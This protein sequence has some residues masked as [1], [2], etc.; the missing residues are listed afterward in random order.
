MGTV[1][2]IQDPNPKHSRYLHDFFIFLYQWIDNIHWMGTTWIRRFGRA[3]KWMKHWH[4]YQMQLQKVKLALGNILIDEMIT[5]RSDIDVWKSSIR[6]TFACPVLSTG[7]VT[8]PYVPIVHEYQ[9]SKDAT[10]P[11]KISILAKQYGKEV[12]S[13]SI[14][15]ASG[16]QY[17]QHQRKKWGNFSNSRSIW[18][19]KVNFSG[20]GLHFPLKI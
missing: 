19:F 3:V 4:I 8:A 1:L 2:S 5:E 16:S 17:S 12:S 20:C 13:D 6:T 15:M 7:W 10:C 14:K 11:N 9:E 18:R